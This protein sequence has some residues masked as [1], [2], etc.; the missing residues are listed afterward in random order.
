MTSAPI[1]KLEATDPVEGFDCGQQN[2]NQ[3]LQRYALSSQRGNGAQT[4]VACVDSIVAGYYSICAASV[5]HA[6]APGRIVKG[7]AR[8]PVPLM[9]LSRLAVDKRFQGQGLGTELLHDALTRAIHAG[10]IMGIRAVVVHPKDEV[11]R[12]W[13][14]RFKFEATPAFPEQLFLLL[15]DIPHILE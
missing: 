11:A 5:A 1:R 13:Y 6:D 3:Y 9:L 7:L 2:L 14:L 8:H 15:K 10:D 4:Y 12:R